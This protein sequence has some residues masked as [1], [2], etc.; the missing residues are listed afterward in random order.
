MLLSRNKKDNVY[1]CKPQF[2]YIKVG[3][4]GVKI[5]YV[6]FCNIPFSG[7]VRKNTDSLNKQ[8]YISHIEG[9]GFIIE[10]GQA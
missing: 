2:Y 9:F 10:L 7:E 3:F 1:P 8:H 6:C 5:I 4:N